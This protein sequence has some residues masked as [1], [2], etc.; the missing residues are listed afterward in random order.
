MVL[1]LVLSWPV[2]G[3]WWR[4]GVG[5][6]EPVYLWWARVAASQ[7]LS[8]VG[9]RPG[10]PALIPALTGTLH[11]PLVAAVASLQYAMGVSAGLAA[12]ALVRGRAHGGRAG[13]ILTGLL[14]GSFSIHLA[15]GFIANLAFALTFLAAA[16]CLARR[17]RR[18][19]VAAAL[20]LG[21]GA[22]SHPQFFVVGAIILVSCAALAWALEPE[23]G[24]RSDAGRVLAALAGAT[25]IVGAGLWAATAGPARLSVYTS[26]DGFLR[27]A[28]LTESLRRIFFV[29]F[30]E[31]VSRF[32]AW[33]TLP[34]AGV[35]LLQVRGFTRRFLLTWLAVT[36]VA[37]PVGIL[38]RWFPPERVLTFSFALPILAALGITWVWERTEPRRW[39]TV[40]VTGVLLGLILFPQI[41]AQGQQEPF[42]SEEELIGGTQAGRIAATLPPGTPLVFIVDD[43]DTSATFIATHVA[44]V[45][46]VAVP[47]DRAGDVHVFVGT[48]DDYFAGRPTVKNS[49]EYDT[50]SRVT[51]EDL[52][53]GPRAT[54]LVKGYDRVPEAFEDSRLQQITDLLWTDVPGAGTEMAETERPGEITASNPPAI[55][56]STLLTIVLLWL[57]G[58]GW[59]RWAVGERFAAWAI[60]PAFGV[61]T[62]TIAALALERL[63]VP[64]AGSW[65]P[66]L[67]S[68]LAGLG[69]YGLSLFQGKASVDPS[70]QIDQ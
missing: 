53:P 43:R 46:R 59:A 25:V 49:L 64:L 45:A 63:G 9:Q 32:A 31:E 61:A 6:D 17:T 18:G 27:R 38:T 1:V 41:N 10:T 39:L 36:V 70:P 15:A 20:L 65:G 24:W 3:H 2:I 51:F 13:W 7:G 8:V 11:L 60:A 42:L 54:F 47:A 35:G 19:T 16:A 48:V 56:G 67:A 28:E 66:T 69:G 5:P 34:L 50:L 57:V 62:L 26:R 12:I 52:P 30:R 58:L 55:L 14:A 37:V 22:L 21:G 23:H 44:N 29:R 4:F 68:A 33:V 40:L